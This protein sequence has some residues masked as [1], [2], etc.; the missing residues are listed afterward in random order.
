M[1]NRTDI[2]PHYFC[3]TEVDTQL[4]N[5]AKAR[6]KLGWVPEI[7]AHQMREEMVASDLPEARRHEL[8]KADRDRVL[9]GAE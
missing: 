6:Q 8:L 9:V 5:A 1:A 4:G 3:P 7:T 2:D